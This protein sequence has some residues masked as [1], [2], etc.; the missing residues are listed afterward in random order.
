MQSRCFSKLFLF[1]CFLFFHSYT[2]AQYSKT[3]SSIYAESITEAVAL[4]KQFIGNESELYNGTNYLFY[5]NNIQDGIPYFESKNF[6]IGYI[7][8]NGIL[9]E[10]IQL[11]Y[12]IV[13][14]E[15]ITYVPNTGFAF[16]LFNDKIS[17]FGLLNHNFIRFVK[18]STEKLMKT[19]F[20]DVLYSGTHNTLYVKHIKNIGED[21]SSGK[22]RNFIIE[23]RAYYL[24]KNELIYHIK[25]KKDVLKILSEKKTEIKQFIRKNDLKLKKNMDMPM[26]KIIAYYDSLSS[27]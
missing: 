6:N 24:K 23:S 1:T 10:N 20:Y 25:N 18:D 2:K 7:V 26:T 12:D 27:K 3:D 4:Y 21:L 11:L 9:Y 19:G 17:S 16:R 13:K 15:V 22:L 5:N 14:E 8:Y